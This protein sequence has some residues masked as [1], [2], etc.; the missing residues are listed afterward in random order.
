MPESPEMELALPDIQ[1]NFFGGIH[2]LGKNR[3][4]DI[5]WRVETAFH[6]RI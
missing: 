6:T 2:T 5:G 3:Q 4:P 1:K